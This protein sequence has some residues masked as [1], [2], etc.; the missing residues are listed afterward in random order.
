MVID[1]NAVIQTQWQIEEYSLPNKIV[2]V[3]RFRKYDMKT[4]TAVCFMGDNG[5]WYSAE[6]FS[7][8]LG[9]QKKTLTDRINRYGKDTR[10]IL[11]KRL[12]SRRGPKRFGNR[13]WQKLSDEPRDANILKIRSGK[14]DGL[15]DCPPE[16]KGR[17]RFPE[18]KPDKSRIGLDPIETRKMLRKI[19]LFNVRKGIQYKKST[20]C[21]V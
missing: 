7:E 20:D 2:K 16:T 14:F 4:P 11:L 3:A 18:A 1:T 17:Y 19:E 12:P 21:M 5:V 10:G 8:W 15:I 6:T 13:A 9:C